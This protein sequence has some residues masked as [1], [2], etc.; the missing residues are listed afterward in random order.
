MR[1]RRPAC[2]AALCLAIAAV[3]VQ[4]AIAVDSA[5]NIGR[6]W[7]RRA[8]HR[9]LHTATTM[10]MP[11]PRARGRGA[12]AFDAAANT[13]CKSSRAAHKSTAGVRGVACAGGDDDD[14][15]HVVP[16]SPNP[17][18]NSNGCISHIRDA[19]VTDV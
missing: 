13:R 11:L 18:H 19:T 16:T 14:D 15:K 4:L 9:V 10:M 7:S 5:G 2:A 6:P 17:L 8:D 12:A 3:V 1:R